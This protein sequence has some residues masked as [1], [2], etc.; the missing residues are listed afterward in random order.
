MRELNKHR[1]MHTDIT[2]KCEKCG[3]ILLNKESFY[4]HCTSHFTKKK[5]DPD[6]KCIC[7]ICK[8]NFKTKGSIRNHMLLHTGE[9]FLR[10]IPVVRIENRMLIFL[11]FDVGK[12]DHV[13]E[14]CGWK[15][16]SKGNLK[17]H[18][19]ST[20][21]TEKPFKCDQCYKR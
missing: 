16:K 15:F 4:A 7:D 13:C 21:A 17:G 19:A 20:H 1:N 3:Q 11:T 5:S 6:E 12:Y 2:Y 14:Q 18:L 8:K 9:C 10:L